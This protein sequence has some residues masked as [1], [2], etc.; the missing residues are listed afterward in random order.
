MSIDG[1]FDR[2]VSE[3]EV[4]GAEARYYDLL[5]NV[6]TGRQSCGSRALGISR[7]TATTLATCGCWWR[8]KQEIENVLR[9]MRK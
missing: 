9:R 6:I 4:A 7:R 3:V 1:S 2:S 8:A 5:M